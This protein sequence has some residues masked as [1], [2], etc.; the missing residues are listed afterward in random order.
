MILVEL[1]DVG[2]GNLDRVGS[3][4]VEF[5]VAEVA[6]LIAQLE[7]AVDLRIRHHVALREIARQLARGQILDDVVLERFRRASRRLQAHAVHIPI[8]FAVGLERGNGLDRLADLAHRHHHAELRVGVGEQLIVD[9]LFEH[10]VLALGR[11]ERGRVELRAEGLLHLRA[12]AVVGFAELV[13]ADFLAVHLGDKRLALRI[14][15][16]LDAEES[17]ENDHDD[18]EKNL[19]RDTG[20]LV[21]QCLQHGEIA[22]FESTAATTAA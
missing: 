21:V 19:G 17:A 1:L 7:I 10:L 22:S 4:L 11:V 18:A 8:E 15:V 3:R 6:G 2:I 20:K 14:H 12:I 16:L 9:Q 13:L 5:D